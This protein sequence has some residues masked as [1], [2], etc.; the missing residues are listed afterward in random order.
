MPLRPTPTFSPVADKALEISQPAIGGINLKDLEYEQEITQSPYM[1]NMMYRNGALSKRYGQ[2][3]SETYTDAIYAFE[4]FKDNLIVHA[5]TKVYKG[6]TQIASGLPEKKGLFI[7][8][9]QNL[10]YFC[11]NIYC[12][13]GTS[14]STVTPY[15]P[16]I[17]INRR[18]DGTGGDASEPYNM[19]GT[20]FE[21]HFHGDGS[22]TQ[23]HLTDTNLDEEVPTVTVDNEQWTYD[24]NLGS[25]KTFKVDYVTGVVTLKSAPAAGT[26]NVEII[27]YKHDSEWTSYHDQI[28]G[29]KYYACF[30]GNNNSR[31]FLAGG[32]KSTYYYSEVFDASY[33]P[34]TNYARLGNKADDITGFGHQYNVLMIF[35]PTE[36]YSLTYYQQTSSTTT[37]ESQIGMGAFSSQIVNSSIGCDCPYT[38]QLINNMLTWF[39][40]KDGIC[41][42]VSTNIQDER[43]VRVISRN[44]ERTNN[45]GIRGILD[46]SE[47]SAKIQ[48]ADFE[49]KY[50]LVFPGN[51]IAYVWDYGVSPYRLSSNGETSSSKLSWFLFDHFYVNMFL[52]AGKDLYYSSSYSGDDIDFTKS[53]IK[54]DNSFNDLDYNGD[55]KPDGIS[56]FYM[57][58]FLQFGAVNMLKNVKNLFVQGRGDFASFIDI[59]YYTNDS[60]VPEHDP[61]SIDIGGKG[62]MWGNF[63][64]GDF[65]W[66]MNI[67]GNTYRRKCNLKKI[68]MCAFYFENNEAG[69]DMSITNIDVQYQ[70]VKYIR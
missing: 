58:P 17:V 7:L 4:E 25:A 41:T 21:N 28:V 66:F 16:V 64:W 35:K 15:V 24:A 31:L 9:N 14:W 20:G 30:G 2:H 37:D 59:Y 57:T 18:P 43:N 51:G 3:I 19:I 62:K 11:T 22:S 26:N 63:V 5:G 39:N 29:S 40:T 13:D 12:Y 53:L 68:Q 55:S 8:F 70:L 65:A 45:F 60:A 10:Y 36:I 54:V 52:K 42:L 33:F 49:N 34:Y 47:D 23:F 56:S 38:I 69:K 32:G 48:S 27:A 50:W 1:L 61:E 67:W 44:I 6:S 46:Y